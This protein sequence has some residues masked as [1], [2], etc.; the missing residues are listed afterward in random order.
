MTEQIKRMIYPLAGK[1]PYLEVF[2]QR[3][4][5]TIIEQNRHDVTS[6]YN[7][8]TLLVVTFLSEEQEVYQLALARSE[9]PL[10]PE[11]FQKPIKRDLATPPFRQGKFTAEVQPPIV[12]DGQHGT[13]VN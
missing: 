8:G 13:S 4:Y 12:N 5:D 3:S 2:L 10:L 7:K 1:V 11:E 9:I 6:E